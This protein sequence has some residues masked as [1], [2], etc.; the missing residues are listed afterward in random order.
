MSRLI[1]VNPTFNFKEKVKGTA[2]QPACVVKVSDW[3]RDLPRSFLTPTA[4]LLFKKKDQYLFLFSKMQKLVYYDFSP[5][6][7]TLHETL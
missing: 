7:R 6:M 4:S 3:N 1:D 5:W 2:L